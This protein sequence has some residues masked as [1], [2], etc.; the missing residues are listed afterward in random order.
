[1]QEKSIFSGYLR[2]SKYNSFA[3]KIA[4]QN[5]SYVQREVRLWP[6]V[7]Y[8]IAPVTADEPFDKSELYGTS[9]SGYKPLIR[10]EANLSDNNYYNLKAF[11]LIYEGYPLDGDILVKYRSPDKLGIPPVRAV[12]LIQTPDDFELNQNDPTYHIIPTGQCYSYDL[13]NYMNYDFK[14][15]QQQVANRYLRI[16]TIPNRMLKILGG[17]FPIMLKGDYKINLLYTLPNQSVPSTSKQVNLYNPF[18]E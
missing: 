7:H 14:D 12:S 15:I 9:F 2:S 6:N 4:G 16:Q 8:L 1:L 10:L 11:P 3:E 5:L 17:E 18:G 13:S